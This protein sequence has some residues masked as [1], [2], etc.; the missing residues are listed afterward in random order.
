MKIKPDSG[1]TVARAVVVDLKSESVHEQDRA[2]MLLG[3]I[4][5]SAREAL[6]ALREA[7]AG[8]DADLAK[9]ARESI[10]KIEVKKEGK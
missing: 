8:K 2:A 7:A 9:L 4:G 10:L 1:E 3:E 6:P 5:P